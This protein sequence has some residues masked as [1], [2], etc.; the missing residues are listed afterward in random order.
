LRL[1][2]CGFDPPTRGETGTKKLSLLGPYTT[3]RSTG[4][5]ELRRDWRHG[6][7]SR[8][9]CFRRTVRGLARALNQV[10]KSLLIIRFFEAIVKRALRIHE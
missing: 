6:V 8:P 7:F 3:K 10:G 1:V 4:E 9:I 2:P 5:G